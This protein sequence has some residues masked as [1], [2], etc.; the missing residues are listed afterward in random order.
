MS[1]DATMKQQKLKTDWR[2]W[3]AG[4]L[5]LDPEDRAALLQLLQKIKREGS[6]VSREEMQMIE[7]VLGMREWKIRDVMIPLSEVIAMKIT[8]TYQ[9]AVNTVREWQHSRYPVVDSGG[10]IVLG[11]LLAKDLLG[12][13]DKPESF[14]MKA[15]MREALFEPDS[16]PLDNLLEDFRT[17]RSHMVIVRD[18]YTQTVGIVTIEDLLERI[19]GEI[20]DESDEDDDRDKVLLSDG[21][22]NIKGTLSIEEFNESFKGELPVHG[23]D[24]IAGWLAA[25]LGRMPKVGDSYEAHGFKFEVSKAN[26]RRVYRITV[27]RQS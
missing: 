25:M 14:S 19:V 24:N 27:T 17:N 4:L 22:G 1:A 20:E 8:D 15:V 23:A 5:G 6:F 11:F 21:T 9:Q 10:D 18:E 16:K 13:T 2:G 7:G 26:N 12:Y 3:F